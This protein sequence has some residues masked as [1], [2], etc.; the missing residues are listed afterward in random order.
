MAVCRSRFQ[1]E[2]SCEKRIVLI[3]IFKVTQI[4]MSRNELV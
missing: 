1:L 3:L 2:K 4:V